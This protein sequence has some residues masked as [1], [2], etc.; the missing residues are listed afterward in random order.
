MPQTDRYESL[1]WL[2]LVFMLLSASLLVAAQD[3]HW[4]LK[5]SA[6]AYH[7]AVVSA[8]H[9]GKWMKN[10]RQNCKGIR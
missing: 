1:W 6:K 9:S 10:K 3:L 7:N 4:S 8:C 2:W 5:H